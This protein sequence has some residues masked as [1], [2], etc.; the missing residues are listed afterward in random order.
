MHEVLAKSDDFEIKS[1][2]ASQGL[3]LDILS[4]DPMPLIRKL[5]REYKEK[6]ETLYEI[7]QD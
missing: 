4:D 5:V 7:R 2:M 6:E 3:A 1:Y